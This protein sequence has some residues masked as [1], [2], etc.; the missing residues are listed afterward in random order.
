MGMACQGCANGQ[1]SHSGVGAAAI[2]NRG[3]EHELGR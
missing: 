1:A 2:E 3:R